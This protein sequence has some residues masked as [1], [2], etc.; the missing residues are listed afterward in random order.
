MPLLYRTKQ[1]HMCFSLKIKQLIDQD[2]PS[3]VKDPL[4]LQTPTILRDNIKKKKI[5][6]LRE[7]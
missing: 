4:T 7:L 2:R 3:A 5:T 1:N 6:L